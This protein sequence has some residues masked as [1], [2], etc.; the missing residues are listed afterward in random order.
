MTATEEQILAKLVE[1]SERVDR[2]A[3]GKFSALR[4]EMANVSANSQIVIQVVKEHGHVLGEVRRLTE[5]LQL[6]CPMILH[7]E[8][9]P[10]D[11]G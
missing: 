6:R 2:L 5:Q 8:A 4:E 7:Q 9:T 1:L 3:N 10:T 11:E